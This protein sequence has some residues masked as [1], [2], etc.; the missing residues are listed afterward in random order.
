PPRLVEARY[1]A[2]LIETGLVGTAQWTIV[3][4]GTVAGI[5][6]LQ[7][8]TLALRQVRFDKED[9]ILGDLGSKGLGLLIEQPGTHTVCVSW[10]A[11]GEPGPAGLRFELKMPSCVLTS[12][13]LEL[14]A[15]RVATVVGE[16]CLLSGPQP[17]AVPDHRTWRLLCGG[18]TPVNLLIRPTSASSE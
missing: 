16:N 11:R 5:L 9:A 4:S 17:A 3:H 18:S 13:E 1:R 6:P 8:L 15:D 10:S 7:P 2:N 12:F 14:P